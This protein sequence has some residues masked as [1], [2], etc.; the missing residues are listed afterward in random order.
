MF[1]KSFTLLALAA[2]ISAPYSALAATAQVISPEADGF[3]DGAAKT[4]LIRLPGGTLVSTFSYGNDRDNE[5]VYDPKA[6]EERAAKDIF[7]TVSNDNGSTW[8]DPI[9]ISNT[10]EL[11]SKDTYWKIDPATGDPEELPSAYYG[12][13]GKPN[14]FNNGKVIAISW[15]DKFCPA[16]GSGGT[17][18]AASS[19]NPDQGAIT[20]ATRDGRQ[21]PYSCAY[22]AF[23]K[24][25]PAVASNWTVKQLTKGERDVSQDVSRGITVKNADGEVVKVPWVMTWQEDPSGLQ[26]GSADGPGDGVSGAIASKGTDIWYTWVDDIRAGDAA[27]S[28]EANIQR[29]TQN[30]T[31]YKRKE[32]D[33]VTVP[34]T[35]RPLESGYEAATRANLGLIQ[36]KEGGA[37]KY[38]TFVAYEETKGAMDEIDF[39]KVVRIHQFDYNQPPATYVTENFNDIGDVEL[40][41]PADTDRIGCIISDPAKNGRRVRFFANTSNGAVKE[42]GA[43]ITLIW[44]EGA[45]DQGGPSDIVSRI[46]YINTDDAASSGIRPQDLSPAVDTACEHTLTEEERENLDTLA[47]HVTNEVGINLSHQSELATNSNYTVIEMQIDTE[48]DTLEDARAHRGAIRGDTIFLGYT[49]TEDSALAKYTD[50]ANYNF[51][52]RRSFD[53]GR[54]WSEANNVTQI[55]DTTVN[56]KEPRIV[57]MPGSE[58]TCDTAAGDTWETNDTCQN[59]NAFIVA[60][61]TAS[62]VYDQ[63]GG[64]VDLDLFITGTLDAG[65]SYLPLALLAGNPTDLNNPEDDE[66]MESQ[67]RANPAGTEVFAAY[68]GTQSDPED[69]SITDKLSWFIAGSAMNLD[70]ENQE[71]AQSPE[72]VYS[73]GASVSS[74]SAGSSAPWILL[75]GLLLGTLRR[76]Y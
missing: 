37:T 13:S 61:G 33:Y 18:T 24:A 44:K 68:N 35:T 46:G 52:I 3:K 21:L 17:E 53:G 65:E 7:V 12:D 41:D 1:R 11:T 43:K 4:K 64:A 2:A 63:L 39:G 36:V 14:I 19:E 60:W 25:D 20:Y 74:D 30:F 27:D 57:G 32:G 72:L 76:R 75:M 15:A 49:F 6:Q 26:P 58:P 55:D 67:L 5:K 51:Y 9:N 29:L 31:N 73:N 45:Y 50:L 10:A 56:V 47:D 16:D 38:K 40:P 54:T 69:G 71:E 23:T 34:L 59:P 22:I 42:S 28:F 66:E 8:S 70:E 48:D 62:N